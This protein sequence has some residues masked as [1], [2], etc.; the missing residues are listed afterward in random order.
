M[1]ELINLLKD[2]N[3]DWV[4]IFSTFLSIVWTGVCIPIWKQVYNY[5]K[6]KK[7]DRYADILYEEVVKAT[8]SVQNAIV[9]D[10]KG[11]TEWTDENKKYVKELA[12]DKAIQALSSVVYKTLK[13]ANN[14]FEEYL[15][16]LVDTALFDIKNGLA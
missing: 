10:I 4:D 15:D 2:T 11:T 6:S 12:K 14:D 13:E 7:L 1:N 16:V 5:L 3:I 9:D 8:K